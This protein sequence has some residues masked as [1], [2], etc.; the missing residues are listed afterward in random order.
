M[1]TV[2]KSVIFLFLVVSVL[3]IKGQD[4]RLTF[5][6]VDRQSYELYQKSDWKELIRFS[7]QAFSNGIDYYYLR[8]RAG[9]A[10]FETKRYMQAALQFE[11]ALEFNEGDFVAGEYLY[12]C[13]IE[14]KR[15]RDAYDIFEKLPPSSREKL[16]HSLPKLKE[17]NLEAAMIVSNQM[18][19]FDTIDLDGPDNIY[20]ETDISQ[21]GQYFSGGLKWGFKNGYS[22]FGSYGYIKIDKRKLA[23]IG[24]S[25]SLD[26]QYPLVQHQ[27]YLNG[28]IPFGK[29][30][31]VLPAFNLVLDRFETVVPRLADDSISYLFPL[32]Q[33][34]YNTFIGYLSVTKDYHI[35]QTS[36]FA[37]YSNL[38]EEEQ[39]QAGV[40]VI[41]FPFGNLNL[42]LCS[43]L[44]DHIN[45]SKGQIIFDQMV[46]FRISANYWAE[47]DA[48]FGRMNNY[49]EG[50][51][52]VVYNIADEMKF[53]AGGKLI[54]TVGDRWFLTAEYMYL[55][56]EGEFIYYKQGEG[57]NTFEA[58]DTRD[59][60]NQI[61]LIGFKWK[62]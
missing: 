13:Y 32:K 10:Y 30:F 53:K 55:L 12:G 27:V 47:I 7:K 60:Y 43:K 9:V 31:S 15:S 54:Y 4:T 56:R 11:K 52:Y 16:E 37:A 33:F 8:F 41:Y 34:N 35:I 1:G 21:D 42:Y 45:N 5:Q 23:Q 22:V 25:L 39:I 29:G 49:H 3:N 19:K 51:A 36:F 26:D 6:E 20:G 61:A 50:N 59:F 62:F 18:E 24:D 17:V 28:N 14:V 57:L 46:G 2:Q 58:S 38:N 44:L 40:Q 48:T